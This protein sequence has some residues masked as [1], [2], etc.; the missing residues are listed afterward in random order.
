MLLQDSL[1]KWQET[2][3]K[4]ALAALP[5]RRDSFIT[6]SSEPVNRLYTPADIPDLDS[7]SAYGETP[8]KALAEVEQAKQA[9]L[10]AAREAGNPI[11]PPF[12]S[13]NISST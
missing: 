5:E 1:A 9:W 4:K 10:V 11:P 2:R 3:L 7:C 6:T 12:Y 8:E 13:V